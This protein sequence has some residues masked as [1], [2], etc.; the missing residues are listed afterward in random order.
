MAEL[1]INAPVGRGQ[2]EGIVWMAARMV[3]KDSGAPLPLRR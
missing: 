2:G 3:G 1:F